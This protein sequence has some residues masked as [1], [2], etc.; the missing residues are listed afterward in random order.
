MPFSHQSLFQF[1]LSKPAEALMCSSSFSGAN[2]QRQSDTHTHTETHI[3]LSIFQK[4]FFLGLSCVGC[5]LTKPIW[6]HSTMQR[7]YP[8]VVAVY[9]W[10]QHDTPGC[11][12]LG[13]FPTQKKREN[14]LG[15][16]L[17]KV[18]R[19]VTRFWCIPSGPRTRPTHNSTTQD[20]FFTTLNTYR[21]AQSH[22]RVVHDLNA[23]LDVRSEWRSVFFNV[24]FK[25]FCTSTV[26]DLVING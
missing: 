26:L 17:L 5:S 24:G 20:P 2:V 14:L 10:G 4:L 13:T 3:P 15:P 7:S 9:K 23:G 22:W 21:Y 25:G 1:L 19:L 11:F 6:W 16:L 18:T 8:P 12:T